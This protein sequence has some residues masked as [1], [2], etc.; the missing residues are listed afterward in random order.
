MSEILTRAEILNRLM[1]MEPVRP[2]KVQILA[3]HNEA[4][5]RRVEEY[6]G[7]IRRLYVRAAS[8]NIMGECRLCGR[9]WED[10]MR[11]HPQSCLAAPGEERE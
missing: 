6:R 4:L 10:E 11:S 9:V 5:R 7:H 1:F 2:E 3:D 8:K